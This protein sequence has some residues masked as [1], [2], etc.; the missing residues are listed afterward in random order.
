VG[1]LLWLFLVAA[2]LCRRAG[3]VKLERPQ[4]RAWQAR[5]RTNEL[6]AGKRRPTI[7]SEE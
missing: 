1:L 5:A 6:D 7:G 3:G 2:G 4:R